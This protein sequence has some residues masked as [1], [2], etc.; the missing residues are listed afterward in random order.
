MR[1]TPLILAAAALSAVAIV[2][3]LSSYRPSTAHAAFSDETSLAERVAKLERRLET[4]EQLVESIHAKEVTAEVND[5]LHT[6]RKDVAEN[7]RRKVAEYLSAVANP[8]K[9]AETIQYLG[10]EVDRHRKL[11]EAIVAKERQS[12]HKPG[13]TTP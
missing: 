1:R 13:A 4:L 12:K 3:A 8:S 2:I 9:D 5:L 11:L 7:L 6:A 10:L